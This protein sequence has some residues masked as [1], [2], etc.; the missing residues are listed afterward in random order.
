MVVRYRYG[1]L[2]GQALGN[3]S[4]NLYKYRTVSMD[5]YLDTSHLQKW[6]RKTLS[7]KDVKKL[8]SL[9]K[10]QHTHFIISLA[11]IYDI[12]DREDKIKAIELARFLDDLPIK[13]LRNAVDLKREEVKNALKCYEM[14]QASQINPFVVDY[15]DT[16]EPEPSSA[17]II[18][19]MR[20][21]SS[22]ETIVSDLMSVTLPERQGSLTKKQI[23]GWAYNNVIIIDKMPNADAK[24]KEMQKNLGRILSEDIITFKLAE[25]VI[26]A[27]ITKQQNNAILSSQRIG[28][29]DCFVNWLLKNPVLIS[30]ICFPYYTQHFMHR[31][32]QLTWKKSHF[33]DLN[34]LSALPYVD[35]VSVDKQI[36]GFAKQALSFAKR[37]FPVDWEKRVIVSISEIKL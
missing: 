17:L 9:K 10:T 31:D 28:S 14:Q 3:L 15:V 24:G 26:N 20:R 27:V 22:I 11:H 6:Q 30:N 19:L 25:A 21:G 18:S 8:D 4:S 32:K 13:W 23:K 5:I 29:V 7:I 33:E 37:H 16:L 34:H 1:A 12:I 36:R 2:K 35:Y